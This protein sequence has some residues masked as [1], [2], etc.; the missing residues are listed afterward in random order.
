MVVACANKDIK[1]MLR[2]FGKAV[3]G[4]ELLELIKLDSRALLLQ[5]DVHNQVLPLSVDHLLIDL[6]CHS[7]VS[8]L[9][10]N[11]QSRICPVATAVD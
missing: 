5:S 8:R 1:Q 9:R 2:V 11:L 3:F 4:H 10:H 6:V 7:E